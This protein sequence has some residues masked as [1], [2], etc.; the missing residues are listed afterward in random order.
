MT[1]ISLASTPAEEA[2]LLK[3]L[4][5]IVLQVLDA[6]RELSEAVAENGRLLDKLERALHKTPSK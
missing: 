1:A 6:T 5:T 4:Q 3:A 2:E